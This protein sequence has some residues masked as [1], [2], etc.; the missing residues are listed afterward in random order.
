MKLRVLRAT[1]HHLLLFFKWASDPMIRR[2]SVFQDPSTLA[3]YK[4]WFQKVLFSRKNCLLIIEGHHQSRPWIPIGQVRFNHMGE[5]GVSLSPAF[6]GHRL[7]TGAIQTALHYF[8]RHSS[9][10]EAF[11]HI[12]HDNRASTRAFERAGFRFVCDTTVQGH[13]CRRYVYNLQM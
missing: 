2:S 12:K 10:S 9:L 6:R 4:R 3:T 8:K 1:P 7:A 11:A 13:A 5:I